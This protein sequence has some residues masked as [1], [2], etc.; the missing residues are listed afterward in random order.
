MAIGGLVKR[1][2]PS[3]TGRS[4]NDKS[5][6]ILTLAER[7]EMVLREVDEFVKTPPPNRKLERI[8]YLISEVIKHHDWEWVKDGRSPLL[9]VKTSHVLVPLDADLFKKA[10]SLI[11]KEIA[12]N[13]P[14]EVKFGILLQDFFNEL[15]IVIGDIGE[16]RASYEPFDPE[17]QGKPWSLG[18]FLNMAHI[19]ISN[20]GGKLLLDHESQSAFPI[21]IRMP[22]D[23][24]I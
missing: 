4:D 13:V 15:E 1:L 7:V 21:V 8:D 2:S 19:I 5:Q 14:Q 3:E 12:L 9:S 18:L 22:R 11:F 17:L 6:A 10:L 24:K 16:N 20:H 23:I